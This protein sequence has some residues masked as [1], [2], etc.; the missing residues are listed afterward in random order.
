MKH[1]DIGQKLDRIITQYLTDY[2]M[3]SMLSFW[4]NK[5]KNFA[6]NRPDE[7]YAIKGT[8]R[9]LGKDYAKYIGVRLI[10]KRYTSNTLSGF[11][12]DQSLIEQVLDPRMIGSF[13]NKL[14]KECNIEKKVKY[15]KGNKYLIYELFMKKED[16]AINFALKRIE[17]VL[18]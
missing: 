18:K 10:Y 9:K 7:W 12:F 15:K 6:K 14:A 1:N 17:G 4:A 13:I 8:K 5:E 16:V 2:Y 11:Y 3:Q